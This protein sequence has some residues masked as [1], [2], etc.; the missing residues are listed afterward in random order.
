MANAPQSLSILVAASEVVGFA[1]TGGLADVAGAL[2]VAL[3]RRGHRTAAILPLYRGIRT[4]KQPIAPTEHTLAVPVGDRIIPCRLWQSTFPDSDVPVYLVEN[5]DYFE[6]DDPSQGRGIYQYLDHT[7]YKR[8]YP[9]SAERYIFF[10]R[11]VMEAIAVLGYPLDILHANDWQTGLLPVYLKELYRYRP[12]YQKIRSLFTIHNIAYQG[13]FKPDVYPLLGLDWR[14]FNH[15][16]MEFWGQVNFLKSG[17]IFAD[18]VNTVSPTYAQEIQTPYYGCGLEGVLSERRNRLSGIVNGIDPDLWNPATDPF[19]P[20][21]Y[22]VESVEIGKPKCKAALQQ[23]FG[24]PQE[25]RSPL[26]GVVA[27]LVDQKGIDIILKAADGMLAKG[28]QLVV[29]GEGDPMYHRMLTELAQRFPQQVGLRLKFDE[30]LAHRI[31]AGADLFLMPSLFEPSGLNQLYSLRF[32]TVPIVRATG[33]LFDTISDSTPEQLSAGTATGFRFA[34]YSAPELTG[35]ID[36]ALEMYRHH[37]E[38]FLQVVRTGMR[39]DW[40]WNRSALGY[41]QLCIRLI[42][43]RDGIASGN[44]DG[45]RRWSAAGTEIRGVRP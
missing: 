45:L 38:Q 19:I 3:A 44:H 41:E 34:G 25:P 12:A 5:S 18:W 29:L 26:I 33:G 17:I 39:Q 42:E 43:E 2:P 7:G 31:E 21:H 16:Q 11:A 1:K 9:D 28:V 35:A 32:G 8:D 4:G 13:T 30:A 23:E 10:C 24:L 14:L 20:A 40:S 6:R 37:P 27:R 15:R 22:D 36:R